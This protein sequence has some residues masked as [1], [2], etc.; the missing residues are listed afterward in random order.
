MNR[1]MTLASS[2]VLVVGGLGCATTSARP[3]SGARDVH[4][5]AVVSGGGSGRIVVS[6]P[7]VVLDLDVE[8][9]HDVA[10][11]TVPAGDGTHADCEHPAGDQGIPVR[12]GH[13]DQVNVR[14]G[15]GEAA[16]VSS[17]ATG[18]AAEVRW[19]AHLIDPALGNGA[20]AAREDSHR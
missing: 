6:G 14:V 8:G 17:P 4:G 12:L 3:R 5:S 2:V 15:T 7:A 20:I 10:L 1:M 18:G 11:Y 16:C 13:S 19:H 9:K